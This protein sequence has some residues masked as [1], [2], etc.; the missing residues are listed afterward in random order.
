[1]TS[2]VSWVGAI[3]DLAGAFRASGKIDGGAR[4][5]FDIPESELGEAIA[6]VA[7]RGCSL[8][9]T[10]E[11]VDWQDGRQSTPEDVRITPGTP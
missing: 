6:L 11:V 9:I 10:V 3:A 8:R 5:I 1:M 4:V 7:L 2:Q